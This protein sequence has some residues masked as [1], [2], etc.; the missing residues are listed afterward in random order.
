MQSPSRVGKEG[1]GNPNSIERDRANCWDDMPSV[2]YGKGDVRKAV[3]RCLTAMDGGISKRLC[4]PLVAVG[5]MCCVRAFRDG[6]LARIAETRE[7]SPWL[8]LYQAASLDCCVAALMVLGR[9]LS[10]SPESK[11][12][13]K[14][15]CGKVFGA[16]GSKEP[17]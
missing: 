12:R 9:V 15:M 11:F 14:V 10:N 6:L 7:T 5:A 13:F 16:F 3:G 1:S 4:G 8:P 17:C 2:P